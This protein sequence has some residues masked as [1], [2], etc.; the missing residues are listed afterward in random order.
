M[1]LGGTSSVMTA[2]VDTVR[3]DTTRRD[4]TDYTALFL[5]SQ[6]ESRRLIPVPPRIGAGALLPP[7]ARLVF[8]RDSIAWWTAETVGD[9][10]TRVPGVFLLRGGWIGRPELPNF[11]AHG[12]ASIEYVMDGIPYHPIGPDSVMVD[13]S[14]LPVSLL[15]RMEIDR[16][17]GLLRVALFTRRNDRSAPYSRIGVSSGDLRIERYQ[18]Q[19]DKRSTRGTGFSLAFDHLGV[20]GQGGIG[21]YTNTHGLIRLEYIPSA[22]AGFEIRAWQTSPNREA[23]LEAGDTISRAQWGRRRDFTARFYLAR[24]DGMGPRVD[25]LLS[26]T[27]WVDELVKDSVLEVT[28]VLDD[29]GLKTGEDSTWIVHKR[30]QGL[31]QAGVVFGY[32]AAGA[33]ADGSVFWRSTWTPLDARLRFGIAPSR[34]FTL[35]VEGTMQRHDGDRSSQFVTARAGLTLP[36]G[37]SAGAAWRVGKQVFHP[38]IASDTAQTIEDRSVTG[39]WRNRFADLEATFTTNKSFVPMGYDQYPGIAFI[40]SSTL[41]TRNDWFT[42]AGRVSP[43]Q[44]VSVSGWFSNPVS[45]PPEGQPPKHAMVAATIQSKFLPTF[46][47]GIFN[48]KLQV[49]MERWGAGVLGQT[50]DSLPVT[51]PAQTYYRGYIGIQLGSFMVWWDRYNMQGQQNVFH[52]PGLL[53]PGFASTFGVRWEFAN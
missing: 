38:A 23:I 25:F 8:D 31:S 44:W 24:K 37:L 39:A 41:L 17:P 15:D 1:L 5:R 27:Q 6:Q 35:S 2:Q 48:L 43:R 51:L 32:R 22:T 18:G 47:S 19:L 14:L 13:P 40:A 45:S 33:A 3:A 12:A 49:S 7:N 20:P 28:D 4:T 11:Q 21:D 46:R 29:Q 36:F 10:L 53:I 42:L 34:W 50:A 26:R 9:L 16:L 30:H 52:V